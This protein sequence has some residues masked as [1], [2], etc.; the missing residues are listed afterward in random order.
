MIEMVRQFFQMVIDVLTTNAATTA[1]SLMGTLILYLAWAAYGYKGRR[2]FSTLFGFAFGLLVGIFAIQNMTLTDYVRVLIPL[3]LSVVFAALAYLFSAAGVFVI[4]VAAV[5]SVCYP[6]LGRYITDED[7]TIRFILA[8]SIGIIFAVLTLVKAQ[9][10]LM[11]VSA[12][13]GGLG[14]SITLFSQL[15]DIRWN[16]QTSLLA[17]II[18]ALVVTVFGLV[19]QFQSTK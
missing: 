14:F 1:I 11:I 13:T 5:C 17:L 18:V 7:G 6:M 19:Y 9:P 2:A 15:V 4:E 12:V 10:I 3:G 16:E 8:L